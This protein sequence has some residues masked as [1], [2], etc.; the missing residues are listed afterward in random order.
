MVTFGSVGAPKRPGYRY[1]NAPGGGWIG[2]PENARPSINRRHIDGPLLYLRNGE[3]HWLTLWER[4]L[5]WL[6]KTDAL[7]LEKKYRPHLSE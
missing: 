2:W 5:L 3:M 6:G 7:A 4:L 1:E